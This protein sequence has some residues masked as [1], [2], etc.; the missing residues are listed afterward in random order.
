MT[1]EKKCIEI[2]EKLYKKAE[3]SL[4][5]HSVLDSNSFQKI[6]YVTRCSTNRSAVRFLMCP[7]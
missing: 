5:I 1:A 4:T 6:N 7:S 2:L 3:Q